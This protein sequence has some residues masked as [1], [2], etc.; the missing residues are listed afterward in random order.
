MSNYFSI[1]I[2]IRTFQWWVLRFVTIL[3]KNE[4]KK[5]QL[6]KYFKNRIFMKYLDCIETVWMLFF[7]C[8]FRLYKTKYKKVKLDAFSILQI[9]LFS[10]VFE[11][12]LKPS[13]YTVFIME[14][15]KYGNFKISLISPIL[16]KLWLCDLKF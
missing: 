14:T 10:H 13:E 12:W 4:L 8:K 7:P 11:Y 3:V 6:C 15:L 9:L 5:I 1:A 2:I 16:H